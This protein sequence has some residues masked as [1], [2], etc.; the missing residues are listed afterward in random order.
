MENAKTTQPEESMETNDEET[1]KGSLFATL[2]FV[3]G[4]IVVMWGAVFWLFMSRV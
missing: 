2:V 4:V 1:L 3:G